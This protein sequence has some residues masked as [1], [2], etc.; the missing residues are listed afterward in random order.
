MLPIGPASLKCNGIGFV[1]M[2]EG[3]AILDFV[4]RHL[5]AGDPFIHRNHRASSRDTHI[6]WTT[7]ILLA[8]T[9]GVLMK[10]VAGAIARLSG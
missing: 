6:F 9:V 5:V 4:R 10:I 8:W 2:D 1:S 3:D 7:I